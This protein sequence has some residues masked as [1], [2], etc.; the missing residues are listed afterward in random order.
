MPGGDEWEVG[1]GATGEAY[2][3]GE[4]VL[5]TG[6]SV[7]NERYGL[8]PDQQRRYRDLTAVAAMPVETAS[9]EVMAVLSASSKEVGTPLARDDGYEEHFLKATLVARILVDLLKWFSD[10]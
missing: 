2:R 1:Q 5:A 8:T 9:G 4:Y 6:D 3:R 10:E 7:W